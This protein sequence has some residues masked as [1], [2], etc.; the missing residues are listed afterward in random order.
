MSTDKREKS[1]WHRGAG[2]QRK[3]NPPPRFAAK[4]SRVSFPV[5]PAASGRR[6]GTAKKVR[7][8]MGRGKKEAQPSGFLERLLPFLPWN[9]T[10]VSG[11][12]KVR[13]PGREKGKK[14]GKRTRP[15]RRPFPYPPLNSQLRA[16][17]W[18]KKGN[19]KNFSSYLRV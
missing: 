1:A 8:P 9:D 13:R 5:P 11:K 14:K 18:R 19:G 7:M 2:T 3:R 12:K 16:S 10:V 6:K 17:K 4:N 15:Q